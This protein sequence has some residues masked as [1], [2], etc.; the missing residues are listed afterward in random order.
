MTCQM[1]HSRAVGKSEMGL[2]LACLAPKPVLLTRDVVTVRTLLAKKPAGI[3][4]DRSGADKFSNLCPV[5]ICGF[6]FF[7]NNCHLLA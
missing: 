5:Y 6:F 4:K 2:T 1:T 3:A 7:S